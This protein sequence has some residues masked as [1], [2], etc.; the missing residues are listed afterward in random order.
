MHYMA[1]IAQ[2]RWSHEMPTCL[3]FVYY[4]S[5]MVFNTSAGA[6]IYDNPPAKDTDSYFKSNLYVKDTGH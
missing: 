6:I 4:T 2:V 1:Y 5:D 3:L